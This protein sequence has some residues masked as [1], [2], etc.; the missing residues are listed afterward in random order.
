MTDL[1]K[2]FEALKQ[3]VERHKTELTRAET[4]LEDAKARLA[5]TVKEVRLKGFDS[6][7]AVRAERER[8]QK[9]VEDILSE[10]ERMMV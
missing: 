6:A 5:E 10:A 8:L 7:G 1:V 2:R 3:R 9:E 4:R